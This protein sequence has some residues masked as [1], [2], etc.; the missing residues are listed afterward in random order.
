M[1]WGYHVQS[2]EFHQW[3]HSSFGSAWQ[4]VSNERPIAGTPKALGLHLEALPTTRRSS[5]SGSQPRCDMI[6]PLEC[7]GLVR[8]VLLG[9]I[10]WI[11]VMLLSYGLQ[12]VSL[13]A[14]GTCWN[15]LLDSVWSFST[16]S[17]EVQNLDWIKQLL[18]RIAAALAV[19]DVEENVQQTHTIG[20]GMV[21]LH[22]QQAPACSDLRQQWC[23][24]VI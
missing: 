24:N 7:C 8:L 16:T 22:Q 6:W 18:R 5:N 20:N 17:C 15:L 3:C 4:M 14:V 11:S 19:D 9:G 21:N 2:Y 13:Y 23:N 12:A 10:G 1:M